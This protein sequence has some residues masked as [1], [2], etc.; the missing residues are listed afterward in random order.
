[1]HHDFDEKLEEGKKFEDEQDALYRRW[2]DIRPASPTEDRRDGIDRWF[3][4]KDSR[5]EFSVQYKGDAKAADT[6]HKTLFIEFVSVDKSGTPGW[7]CAGK[8]EVIS[9]YVPRWKVAYWFDGQYLRALARLWWM[10]GYPERFAQNATYT[11][12]GLSVPTKDLEGVVPEPMLY[13]IGRNWQ[14]P[15]PMVERFVTLDEKPG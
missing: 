8:A 12:K 9:I 10:H 15:M 1:M 7:A 6:A 4:W 5:A 2:W 11:S 13:V 3:R 14:P